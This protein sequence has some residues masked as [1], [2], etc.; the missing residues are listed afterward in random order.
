MNT[1]HSQFQ[2]RQVGVA[3]VRPI[4]ALL[5]DIVLEDGGGFGIVSVQAIQDGI[6]MLWPIRGVIESDPHG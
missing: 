5:G 4:L 1:G 3:V 2:Q 6:D